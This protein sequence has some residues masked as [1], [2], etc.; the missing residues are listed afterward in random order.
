MKAV[1]VFVACGFGIF[2][3]RQD[4]GSFAHS[5][6]AVSLCRCPHKRDKQENTHIVC[7]IQAVIASRVA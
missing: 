4:T 1:K 6:N 5:E 2:A 7:A 3:G